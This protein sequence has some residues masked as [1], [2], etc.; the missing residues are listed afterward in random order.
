[1]DSDL[2]PLAP[3]PDVLCA[4]VRELRWR[5]RALDQWRAETDKRVGV[6]ESEIVTEQ[7]ARLLREALANHGR[8]QLT[9]WQQ[10]GGLLLLVVSIADLI[11]AAVAG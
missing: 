5:A 11:R 2:P 8:L 10:I 3:D 1:M 9:K 6:L 7:Q 4:H